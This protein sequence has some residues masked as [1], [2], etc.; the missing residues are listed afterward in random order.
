MSFHYWKN[1]GKPGKKNFVNLSN[2][3]HGETLGA[4][5][6]GD[7]SLYKDT[8]NQAFGQ[9]DHGFVGKTCQDHVLQ[10]ADLFLDGGV[11]ARIGVPEQVDPPGT[12]RIDVTVALARRPGMVASPRG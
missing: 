10:L 2:S 12:D 1:H 5:A 6:L 3:Y 8:F 7:V 9:V 4:L 11:D